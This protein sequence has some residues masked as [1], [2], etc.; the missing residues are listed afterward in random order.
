MQ[1]KLSA[2][3]KLLE[4]AATL[5]LDKGYEAVSVND[6]CKHAEVS[7]GSFYH[8]FE[9]KQALFMT[10]MENW[11][12]RVM[13]SALSQPISADSKIKNVL[14]EM[15]HQFNTAFTAIP[16]GFPILVDFWRQAMGDPTVWKTA[17]EPYR[18]FTGFF[19]R[20]IE[21]GQ[22][23]GSIRKDVDSEVLARLL[24]AVAMGYLLEATYDQDKADWSAIT[25]EG[26]KL[27]LEGIGGTK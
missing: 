18:Y 23:D 1:N 10:L 21:T 5:F 26:L 2:R 13:Q 7:K 6:I 24:V 8:Y 3:D 11:S 9:T 17:V 27:L 15:P 4:S 14:I 22:L 19:M 16:K 20:I 25:S 12:S